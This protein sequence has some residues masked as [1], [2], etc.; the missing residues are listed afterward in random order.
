MFSRGV[1]GVLEVLTPPRGKCKEHTGQD[2]PEDTW[3][4]EHWVWVGYE[5][6]R[7]EGREGKKGI[8]VVL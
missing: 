7:G 2:G 6:G 8:F 3:V 5:E 4:E 1:D